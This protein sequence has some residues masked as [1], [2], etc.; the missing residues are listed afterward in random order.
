MAAVSRKALPPRGARKPGNQPIRTPRVVYFA[1][2]YAP[3]TSGPQAVVARDLC[4][5]LAE[6][7]AAVLAVA[8]TPTHPAGLARRLTLSPAQ[9]GGTT[10]YEGLSIDGRTRVALIV[11]DADPSGAR[12]GAWLSEYFERWHDSVDL[13]CMGRDT[14]AMRPTRVETVLEERRLGFLP[15]IDQIA[16]RAPREVLALKPAAKLAVQRRLGLPVR[17]HAP[18]IVAVGARDASLWSDGLERELDRAGAQLVPEDLTAD[19]A[20]RRELYAAADFALLVHDAPEDGPG[21]LAPA[22]FGA[23]P[24]APRDGC[25]ETVLTEVHLPSRTGT[26]FLFAPEADRLIAA[27]RAALRAYRHADFAAVARHASE[28]DLGWARPAHRILAALR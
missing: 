25:Y 26:S 28:L 11:G 18:L 15:G 3:F 10:L 19:L 5:A 7:G 23:V 24:I 4:A 27:T 6:A 12:L 9:P 8:R 21:D 13:V 16:F 14:E 2:G 22:A 20:Q 1:R 17:A